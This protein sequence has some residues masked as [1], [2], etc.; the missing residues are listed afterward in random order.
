MSDHKFRIVITGNA[1]QLFIP[2][3]LEDVKRITP[4]DGGFT[5]EYGTHANDDDWES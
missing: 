4:H 5:F 2:A 3:I 1:D